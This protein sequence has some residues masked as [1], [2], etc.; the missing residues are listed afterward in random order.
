MVAT[1]RGGH[2]GQLGGI[3]VVERVAEPCP[4]VLTAARPCSVSSTRVRGRS[5][6]AGAA[7]RC[8]RVQPVD[9]RGD[10]AGVE[11][12]QRTEFAL[13][14]R[15]PAVEVADRPGLADIHPQS[16]RNP[17]RQTAT[18]HEWPATAAAGSRWSGW[19]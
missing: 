13:S 16:P 12:E 11:S 1:Q 9:Q 18:P 3:D 14:H 8:G 19:T 6:G 17:H 4:M 10:A 5:V 15:A 2:I 7:G